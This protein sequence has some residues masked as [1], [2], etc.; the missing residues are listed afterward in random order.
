MADLWAI[1]VLG[2]PS[3]IGT[4][5]FIEFSDD[6]AEFVKAVGVILA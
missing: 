4:V 6:P 3:L 2:I 1:C 5:N